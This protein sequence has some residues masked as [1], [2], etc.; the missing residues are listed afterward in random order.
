M[1]YKKPNNIVLYLCSESYLVCKV[2]ILS[3]SYSRLE[4]MTRKKC[5]ENKYKQEA[6]RLENSQ[7]LRKT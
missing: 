4:E 2:S 5:C 3:S 6:E 1:L 7:L